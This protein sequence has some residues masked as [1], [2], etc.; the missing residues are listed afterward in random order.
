MKVITMK[1]IARKV[2]VTQQTVSQVLNNYKINMV[3]KTTREKVMKI[4]SDLNYQPNHF[5]ASL[6]K[7][8]TGIIGITSGSSTAIRD[9]FHNPY[10][11]GVIEGISEVLPENGYKLIFHQIKQSKDK[12]GLLE[13]E[14]SNIADGMIYIL[15][16]RTIPKFLEIH[17][18]LLSSMKLPFV[19]IHSLAENFGF[20]A[21]GLDCTR[22]GFIATNHLLE[23]GFT[24][25]GLVIPRGKLLPHMED[26]KTGYE[27]ALQK[28]GISI[29]SDLLFSPYGFYTEEGYAFA[30]KLLSVKKDLPRAFF[31]ANEHVAHG[32]IGRFQEAGIAIPDDIALI[33]FGD[34]SNS[35]YVYT[36]LTS[37]RQPSFEKGR[38]AA[39]I[40]VEA[41]QN[42]EET[43]NFSFESIILKPKLTIRKSC[44]C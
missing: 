42:P 2:G 20:N 5:A 38:Q 34:Y 6:K 29:N 30:D 33:S 35:K 7:G 39:Q 23:H 9:L 31:V 3:G 32:M 36:E 26:L 19:I 37:V 14:Q 15:L 24:E 40:L 43:L 21:V 16:S 28:H 11:M 25:I 18:P 4:A 44:G 12:R 27:Q 1:D 17:K 8:K 41:M 22:G 10:T 13:L